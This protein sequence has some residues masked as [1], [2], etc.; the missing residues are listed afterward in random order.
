MGKVT[1]LPGHHACDEGVTLVAPI[2]LIRVIQRYTHPLVLVPLVPNITLLHG[3]SDALLLGPK[4]PRATPPC[5]GKPMSTV[6]PMAWG[7]PPPHRLRDLPIFLSIRWP[8]FSSPSLCSEV[9]PSPDVDLP[10]TPAPVTHPRSCTTPPP[11][12]VAQE[13]YGGEAVRDLARRLLLGE[14]E[15]ERER[16]RDRERDPEREE[17][18]PLLMGDR[19]RFLDHVL[20][21]ANLIPDKNQLVQNV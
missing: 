19:G 7:T 21:Q 18:E 8:L 10:T 2:V 12:Q 3:V 14:P 13:T 20:Y 5:G 4:P 9:E 15:R 6:C 17:R 16:D 11:P 1:V